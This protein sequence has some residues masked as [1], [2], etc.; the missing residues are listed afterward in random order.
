MHNYCLAS[1]NNCT[2]DSNDAHYEIY[3]VMVLILIFLKEGLIQYSLFY[4]HVHGFDTH[5]PKG[6]AI[7]ADS[8]SKTF[9]FGCTYKKAG[10]NI[11]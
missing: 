9:L 10:D 5:I 4:P 3:K 2:F 11:L 7:F 1:L 8:N 6:G